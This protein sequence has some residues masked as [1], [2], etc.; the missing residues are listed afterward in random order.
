MLSRSDVDSVGPM[1]E[2]TLRAW[3]LGFDFVR[4]DA[5]LPAIE[6]AFP[7]ARQ[8]QAPV[9]VLITGDTA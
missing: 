7:R 5:D 2:P 6:A 8:L 9:A 3:G 4:A 1:T